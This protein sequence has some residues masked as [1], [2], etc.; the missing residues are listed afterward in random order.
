MK[1]VVIIGLGET[2]FSCVEYFQANQIAVTILDSREKPPKL[3]DFKAK[4][5]TVSVVT[6]GFPQ[7]ILQKAKLVVLSPGV[8]KDHPDIVKAIAKDAEVIGDIELFARQV[9]APVV[10]ITGSNGKSTVT[11][12]VGEMAKNTLNKVGV[13]GNLGTP[14]LSLL[15]LDADLYVLELSSFQL[16]TTY[17]LHPKIATILNLS[18]DHLDRYA[19]FGDYHAAKLRIY[20]DCEQIVL[21]TRLKLL[22]SKQG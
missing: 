20:D 5:P 6:G 21:T 7:E 4:Y 3:A 16:E 9:T 2:G 12:L 15:S 8:S 11:T 18:M 17:S 14:A 10:A 22:A 1:D 13:G 19:S